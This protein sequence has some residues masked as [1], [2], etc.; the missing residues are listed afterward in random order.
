VAD[1]DKVILPGQEGKISVT[2]VGHKMNAGRFKKKFTVKTND[3]ENSKI[4]LTVTGVIKEVLGVSKTISITGFMGENIRQEAIITRKTDDNVKI[5]GY[6][7]SSKSRDKEYFEDAVGVKVTPIE[8]NTKYKLE[9]WL[10]KDLKP[11]QYLADLYLETDFDKLPEKKITVRLYI[12]NDVELHPARVFMREMVIPEGT[13]KSFDKIVSVIASRGDSLKILDI[14]PSDETI[15]YNV[16]EVQPG[17]AFTCRF[18]IRPPTEPG[19]YTASLKFLTNYPGYE[20]I[21]VP[22]RGLV[23]VE[24]RQ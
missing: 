18:Q 19:K 16:K 23:R 3:P 5:L 17:K 12:M 21:E 7:W 6:H 22:I 24:R 1:Y 20:E 8:N 13:T 15:T 2:L 9:I 14:I 4:V 10:K 11:K